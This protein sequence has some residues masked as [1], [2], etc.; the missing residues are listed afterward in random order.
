MEQSKLCVKAEYI[1][2]LCEN[3]FHQRELEPR[4][5]AFK[6]D[7]ITLLFAIVQFRSTMFED[8]T[9]TNSRTRNK[10]LN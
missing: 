6:A 2:V 1:N 7:V 4:F 10:I 8:R 9:R 5:P 3:I